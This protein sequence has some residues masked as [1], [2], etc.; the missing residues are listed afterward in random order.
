MGKNSR[1]ILMFSGFEDLMKRIEEAGKSVDEVAASVVASNAQMVRSELASFMRGTPKNPTGKT[2]K[3][4]KPVI[5]DKATDGIKGKIS[6]T[7]G[8]SIKDGGLPA[9][10]WNYGATVRGTPREPATKFIDKAFRKKQLKKNQEE[11][12]NK[13]LSRIKG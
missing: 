10:F 2:L 7:V 3:S 6:S 1:Q 11:V 4:L 8:F 5:V 12:M 9:L 13:I